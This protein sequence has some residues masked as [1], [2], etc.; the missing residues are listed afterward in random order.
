MDSLL[1]CWVRIYLSRINDSRCSVVLVV[2][3]LVLA[4]A[5]V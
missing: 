2:V 1:G 5:A 3:V 4:D